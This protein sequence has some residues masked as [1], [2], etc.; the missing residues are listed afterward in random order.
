M[1]EIWKIIE[2]FPKY[3]VSSL[4]K[5]RGLV[6]GRN[7]TPTVNDGYLAVKLYGCCIKTI[8]VHRLVAKAFLENPDDLLEVNH[9]DG[10]K[11]NNCVPN[12]EWINH[13]DNIIHAYKMGLIPLLKGELNGMSK[14]TES[15][16]LEIRNKY[17]PRKYSCRKLAS[18]YGISATKVCQIINN[19]AWSHI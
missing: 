3:E 2:E 14:L 18:E 9:K 19:K 15:Q 1:F 13:R 11:H 16:V 5:V 4:G 17:I 7:L 12:L 6:R 8:K 10:N